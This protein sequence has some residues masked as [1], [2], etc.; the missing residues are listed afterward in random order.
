M[1][2]VLS[3]T[4]VLLLIFI[5]CCGLTTFPR[6]DWCRIVLAVVALLEMIALVNII[7]DME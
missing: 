2:Y 7:I 1:K 5:V 6:Y 3:V 4:V